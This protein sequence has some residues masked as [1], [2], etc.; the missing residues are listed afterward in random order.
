MQKHFICATASRAFTR[1]HSTLLTRMASSMFYY[2]TY[3]YVLLKD[4]RLGAL[5]Y[6]LAA[7][8]IINMVVKIFHH[9]AL[10]DNI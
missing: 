1:A 3:K 9:I 4:A 6:L 5:Y 2:V 7:T 8:I 10:R